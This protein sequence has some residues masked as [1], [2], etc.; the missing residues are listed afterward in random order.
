MMKYVVYFENWEGL[1]DDEV[2]AVF[3]NVDDA[4]EFVNNKEEEEDLSCEEGY[5]IVEEER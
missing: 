2:I 4:I 3:D 1:W 5:T